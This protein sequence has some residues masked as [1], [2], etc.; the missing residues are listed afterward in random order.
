[1]CVG[2]PLKCFHLRLD[3]LGGGLGKDDWWG[4]EVFP[5]KVRCEF[6]TNSTW[7]WARE[8]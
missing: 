8:G 3:V 1:M 5:S 6:E 2:L 7:G 4:S